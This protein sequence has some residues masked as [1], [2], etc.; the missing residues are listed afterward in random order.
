MDRPLNG[1]A[2]FFILATPMLSFVDLLLITIA[3][4]VAVVV[5]GFLFG[6]LRPK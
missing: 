2:A 6:V 4:S 3:A 1:L 5:V